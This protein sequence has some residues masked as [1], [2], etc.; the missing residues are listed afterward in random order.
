[1]G[2]AE[3]DDFL[4]DGGVGAF[5]DNRLG[6]FQLAVGTIHLA[7]LAN[8]RRHGS[9]NNNVGRYVQVGNTAVGIDHGQFR[10]MQVTGADRGFDLQ[11]LGYR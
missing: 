10:T 5:R 2:F 1:M 3:V 7:A 9:I 8:H 6:I 11:A 4:V